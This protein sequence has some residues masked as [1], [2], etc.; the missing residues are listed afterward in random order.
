MDRPLILLS[1]DDGFDAHGLVVLRRA[2]ERFADVIVCAPSRNQSASSHALTLNTVL[3]LTRIDD[4]TFAL[5]GTP[6]DCIYVAL[7]SKEKVLPRR[8]DLV[9]SG[10]N[11]GPNLSVDI[12][13]SGTVA[14]AREAA[15][16]G[17]PA[18][19]V[20]ADARAHPENAAQLG[21]DVARLIWTELEERRPDKAPLLN[22]NIP[23]GQ[24]WK[25]CSTRL[26]RRLYDDDV[27]YRN[28]PRH[29]EYLWIGGSRARHEGDEDTDT[30]AWDQGHASLTP[31][32]L[33]LFSPEH[34]SL[35]ESVTAR[36][37]KR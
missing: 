7:H 22:L 3:R 23:T 18:L 19:A 32:S 9:V 5:D 28:D 33:E 15:H 8:P 14:A 27:L 6:A 24:S 37:A 31:I 26:G 20:S 35:A 25:V 30:G 17:I 10:M 16:R 1:N 13:Y 2:L 4:T 12:V 21:A 34:A 11:L 29:R 36:A